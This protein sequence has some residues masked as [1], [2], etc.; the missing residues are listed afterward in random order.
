MTLNDK[1]KYEVK[2][3][4]LYFFPD[5]RGFVKICPGPRSWS[6]HTILVQDPDELLV[7]AVSKS[8]TNECLHHCKQ[9]A[10]DTCLRYREEMCNCLPGFVQRKYYVNGEEEAE[11]FV[12]KEA[13]TTEERKNL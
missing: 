1:E 12:T 9:T 8:S 13:Y 11:K 5:P 3:Q 10:T 2:L 7:D 4:H 6:P